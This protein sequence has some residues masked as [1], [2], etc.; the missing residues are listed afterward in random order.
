MYVCQP[1]VQESQQQNQQQQEYQQQ[2][3]CQQQEQ[4]Q[5]EHQQQQSQQ[6]QQLPTFDESTLQ[7]L[8]Q[9]PTYEGSTLVCPNC[10]KL[11]KSGAG[12]ASHLRN[13]ACKENVL[14]LNPGTQ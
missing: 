11:C 7:Q 3:Q 5:Q 4:Y 12:L 14:I 2:Q 8:L 6:Q 9:L 13:S 1:I 10:Q